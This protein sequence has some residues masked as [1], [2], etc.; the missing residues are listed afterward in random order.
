MAFLLCFV[1]GLVTVASFE[2]FSWSGIV[3]FSLAVLCYFFQQAISKKQ[4]FLYGIAFGYGMFGAG[5]SWVYVSLS[6]YGGMPLW[7]GSLAIIGFVGILSLFCGFVGYFSV[8]LAPTSGIRRLVIIPPLWV[9]FEWLKGWVLTGFP[10]LDIGYTQT[11][12]WFFS[13][14][15]IG[16]V[17]LISFTVIV[18]SCLLVAS[19]INKQRIFYL[20]GIFIITLLL[21]PLNQLDWSEDSGQ[22]LNI[23][24]VQGNIPIELKWQADQRDSFI[25]LYADQSRMLHEQS[26]IDLFVWP[27]TALPLYR[28]Q[29]D[30]AFWNAITPPASAVLTGIMDQVKENEF[31]NAAVLSCGDQQQVYRKRHLVPFGEYLPLRFLFG[32][33]LDY[34]QFPMSDFSSWQDTQLLDCPGNINLSLSICY[35]DAFGSEWRH[36]I[37]DSTILVNISEDAWFGDSLAPHQRLQMAQMRAREFS[38]PLVR[39]ANTG[40][41][42]VID[43]RG[44]VLASTEQFVQQSISYRIQPQTGKTWYQRFGNWIII[45]SFVVLIIVFT[46][47]KVRKNAVT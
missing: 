40:P 18:L 45:L 11:P 27:E 35:E 26:P 6:T 19:V 2:P 22:P 12:T 29:T 17:Y 32:W 21:W 9:I 43:Q 41:S 3:F 10:W 15:P 1:A 20:L 37:D 24:L 31:Y 36:S 28:Q 47:N 46:K 38:K 30:Q 4:A 44:N 23:G 25:R 5:V 39:S 16:G 13:L 34:L 42:V 33:V 14:A 7:M 8:L